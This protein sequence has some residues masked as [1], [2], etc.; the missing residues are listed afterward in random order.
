LVNDTLDAMLGN[1]MH[2][3]PEGAAFLEILQD[4]TEDEK[5]EV[6]RDSL[7]LHTGNMFVT[8]KEV[9]AVVTRLANIIANALNIALHPGIGKEDINRFMA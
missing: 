7:G 8:P 2:A 5:Y 9:D 1:L 3:L 4:L 6:V